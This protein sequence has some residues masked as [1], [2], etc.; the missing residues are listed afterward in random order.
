MIATETGQQPTLSKKRS[1]NIQR[2]SDWKRRIGEK[3]LSSLNFTM[4]VVERLS[5]Y[6]VLSQKQDMMHGYIISLQFSGQQGAGIQCLTS[7]Q[8]LT[9]SFDL[10]VLILEPSMLESEFVSLAPVGSQ[11]STVLRFGDFFDLQHFNRVSKSLGYA[12]L[13]TKEEFFA[14]APREIIFVQTTKKIRSVNR[15][16]SSSEIVWTSESEPNGDK[17]CYQFGQLQSHLTLLKSEQF[18]VVR[19]VRVTFVRNFFSENFWKIIYGDKH[20]QDVTVIFNKWS[21]PWLIPNDNAEDP[22]K[23]KDVG[24][25]ST[26]EQFMP[27]ARLIVD[28]KHYENMYLNS[29]NEVAL[30]VRFEHMLNYIKQQTLSSPDSKK[31]TVD[32]CVAD[33]IRAMKEK[34]I[35]GSPMVTLDV[36]RFGSDSIEMK[37]RAMLIEKS[38]LILTSL[39]NNGLSFEEWEDSF[40]KATGGVEHGGYIAALQRTLA[41][42]AKCLILVG[43][44]N[45]QDLALK[46]YIKNH[47][48]KTDQCIE[49]VCVKEEERFIK[50]INS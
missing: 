50:V 4:R 23:C 37:I 27:S 11:N 41:S 20:P 31:I 45:F 38:K 13:G 18:C 32:D 47:P 12:L 9:A 5:N 28:A 35:S 49:F 30:M 19:I 6:N 3:V 16:I 43:G 25:N 48:N 8:C 7:L 15:R 40:T 36:G 14:A 10:P 26:K 42:R 29:Q 22:N 2:I 39:F 34:Q 1:L 17:Y 44:G 21:T 46:D 24:R 33:T